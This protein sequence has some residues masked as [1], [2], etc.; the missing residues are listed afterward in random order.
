MRALLILAMVFLILGCVG[1]GERYGTLTSS[2]AE[3]NAVLDCQCHE[4]PWRYSKHYANVTSCK[5]CH[6]NEILAFHKNLSEWNWRDVSEVQCTLCHDSS[7]LANHDGK[8]E[9]CHKSI[10][11]THNVYLSKFIKREVRS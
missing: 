3:K 6:G 1:E 4:N 9:I 11:E 10:Y 2:I 7:L 8:C 5:S